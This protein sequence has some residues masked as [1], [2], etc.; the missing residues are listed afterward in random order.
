MLNAVT[1]KG[2]SIKL[3]V[4]LRYR[5]VSR[6]RVIKGEGAILHRGFVQALQRVE[7]VVAFA[8][9]HIAAMGCKLFGSDTE[10]GAAGR[11][12]RYQAQRLTPVSSTQF[13]SGTGATMSNHAA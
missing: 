10:A 1:W 7:H 13:S 12:A 5:S 8:A 6:W 9:T 11:A 4:G 2:R 3:G